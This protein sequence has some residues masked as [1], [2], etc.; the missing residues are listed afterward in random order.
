MEEFCG[1]YHVSSKIDPRIVFTRCSDEGSLKEI[2]E[3]A[4]DYFIFRFVSIFID[5]YPQIKNVII[6]Q[7]RPLSGKIVFFG[8]VAIY[9]GSINPVD[10][11]TGSFSIFLTGEKEFGPI[12]DFF[13]RVDQCVRFGNLEGRQ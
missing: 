7:W 2:L 12:N 8:P 9:L 10:F 11:F 13:K 5:K 3:V 1:R 4:E 6:E